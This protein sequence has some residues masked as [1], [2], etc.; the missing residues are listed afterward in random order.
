MAKFLM[1]LLL[2]CGG[3]VASGCEADAD[4]DDDGGKLEVDVD[5]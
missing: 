2:L 4:I 5:D 1:M 3:F